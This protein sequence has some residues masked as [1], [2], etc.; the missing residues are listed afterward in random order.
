MNSKE[1][2]LLEKWLSDDSFINWAKDRNDNDISKWNEFFKDRLCLLETGEIGKQVIKGIPFAPININKKKKENSLRNF[3]KQVCL[4][5]KKN[6]SKITLKKTLKIVASS[7]A[8]IFLFLLIYTR[9]DYHN[10]SIFST[11]FGETSSCILPDNSKIT[12]N[13]NSVLRYDKRYPREVWID[14]EAF[15]EIV[16]KPEAGTDFKVHSEDA[17]ITVLG[18]SF[19]VNNRNKKTKVYLKEGKIKL[20]FKQADNAKVIEMNSGDA[21][22]YSGEKERFSTKDTSEKVKQ[23]ISWLDGSIT[24]KNENIITILNKMEEIYGVSFT[25]KSEKLARKKITIGIPID[26]L[27]IALE[28]IK[29]SLN[30]SVTR[31]NNNIMIKEKQ[32][33][34]L[35]N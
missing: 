20:I 30:T 24:F 27:S 18:T 9:T 15:F 1:L 3:Q 35:S 4:L 33:F 29:T 11:Q 26:D 14:G 25:I 17:M 32:E 21:M 19:N 34:R 31:N 2:K 28:A 6:Q 10:Q 13:A 7:V 5:N 22:G 8:I 12:L 23:A 16:K